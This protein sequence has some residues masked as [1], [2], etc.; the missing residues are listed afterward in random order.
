M[1][2][3]ASPAPIVALT[4][5]RSQDLRREGAQAVPQRAVALKAEG[6]VRVGFHDA[7]EP[8]ARAALR[9]PEAQVM[10]ANETPF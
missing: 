10:I 4:R 9:A 8:E 1:F 6:V 3:R 7:A 2:R 5:W